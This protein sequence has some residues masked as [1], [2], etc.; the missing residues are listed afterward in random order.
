MGLYD[1]GARLN[2]RA[3]FVPDERTVHETQGGMCLG[4]RRK[5]WIKV[6]GIRAPDAQDTTALGLS[7]FRSPESRWGMQQPRRQRRTSGDTGFQ[8]ITSA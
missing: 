4:V 3:D 7:R 2:P 6:G 8:Q 5:V 1:E